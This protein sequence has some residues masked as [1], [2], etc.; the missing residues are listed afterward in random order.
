MAT[1][2]PNIAGLNS[3]DDLDFETGYTREYRDDDLNDD[4]Y[5]GLNINSKYHDATSLGDLCNEKNIPLFL[6]FNIQSL[7][8][9]YEAL[10]N[11]IAELEL[12]K[13][14]IDAIALQ[15][16][17]EIRYPEVLCLPGFKPIMFKNRKGMRGG[18]VGF[19]IRENLDAKII[20]NL[21]PF[22]NKIMEA[23][24][25]QLTYPDKSL[26]LLTSI[27][28]SN[29][30]IPNVTPY[31]QL[32]RFT[33]KFDELLSSLQQTRKKSLI[34]TDSNI[35]LLDLRTGESSNYLNLILGKGYIQTIF[36]ATRIQNIS[37]S[38]ID[39]ILSNSKQTEIISGTLV[40]DV[41]DHFFSFIAAPNRLKNSQSHP[42]TLNRDF[43]QQNLNKFKD[44]IG[45]AD[46]TNVL[47]GTDVDLSY[48]SFWAIYSDLYSSN[49]PLKRQRTNKNIHKAQ[50]FMT[51]G[52]LIS[53]ESKNIL[54]KTAIM[55]PTAVNIL[56][57][58]T[59][60]TVYQK[61]IRGAKK[62]YFT[63]K[64]TK[65]ASNPKKTWETLNE[66]LGKS[67]NPRRL[68]RSI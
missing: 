26:V 62:L 24:T 17:W 64:L 7:H 67:K 42:S 14:K 29:G 22:E 55:T 60:K 53:R 34:F 59:F 1:V 33:P 27:Y 50:N 43:S 49:F 38:L 56:K 16:T 4:P 32:E 8:S 51:Q 37:K 35:D 3:R 65:N 58:K 18:G 46:W 52:I 66:I 6:S 30:P 28:R 39:H 9:K 13:I 40:S 68:D 31:Q 20:E 36:K 23:I 48:S 41:S 44:D 2:D 12:K 25:I 15:E 47:L 54:H 19:Y 61:I 45:A 63:S 11:E 10:L 5:F 57:Y 21:S